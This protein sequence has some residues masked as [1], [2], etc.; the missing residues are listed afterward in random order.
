MIL[1]QS[2]EEAA[3][4]SEFNFTT[5]PLKKIRGNELNG[6]RKLKIKISEYFYLNIVLK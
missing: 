3:A 1:T 4:M 6:E 2:E 5:A